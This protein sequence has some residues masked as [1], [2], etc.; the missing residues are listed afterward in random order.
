FQADING[1]VRD[2]RDLIRVVGDDET[3]TYRNVRDARALGVEGAFGW[4]SPR[5]Y[6]SLTGNTTYVDFRNTSKEGPD[7]AYRGDRI[8]NRPYFFATGNARLQLRHVASPRDELSLTWTS[9]Y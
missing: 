9:R 2:T 8:P 6:V 7:V 1:F 4:I 3:A 5:E